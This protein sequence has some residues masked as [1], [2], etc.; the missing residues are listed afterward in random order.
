MKSVN[1]KIFRDLTRLRNRMMRTTKS[2]NTR[3]TSILC[4]SKMQEMN[5]NYT[6]EK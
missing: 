4:A 6:L 5:P 2:K 1:K 3:S